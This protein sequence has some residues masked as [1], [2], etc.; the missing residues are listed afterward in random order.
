[1]RKA[2]FLVHPSTRNQMSSYDD[3]YNSL[4]LNEMHDK[5]TC[6]ELLGGVLLY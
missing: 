3:L 5:S 6:T 4:A 1:M 2:I